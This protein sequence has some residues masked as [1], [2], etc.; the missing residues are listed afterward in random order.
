MNVKRMFLEKRIE[1]LWDLLQIPTRETKH[2]R[3]QERDRA[4]ERRGVRKN[5]F[6][7]RKRSTMSCK[8]WPVS[9]ISGGWWDSDREI[10]V[11]N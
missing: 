3:N 6:S 10:S 8:E 7:R 1:A 5:C 11:V 4:G 2:I 9:E